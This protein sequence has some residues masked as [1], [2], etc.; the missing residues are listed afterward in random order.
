MSTEVV[1]FKNVSKSYGSTSVLIDVNLAIGGGDFLVTYGLPSSGKS[2]LLRLLVGLEKMDSG[3]IELRGR[4]VSGL[5]PKA[6]GLRYIPQD[7]A[8]FP[9]KTVFENIAYPLRLLREASAGIKPVV[10]RAAEMLSIGDLLDKLPTQ[11]SGG[12]KQRV[13]IAR[14]IVKETDVYILDDPLAGLDFKLR[15]KLIDDLKTLQEELGACFI[16]STSDPVEAMALATRLA[17]LHNG[18]VDETGDPEGLYVDPAM[19]STMEILGFPQTNFL[20]G[21]IIASADG[22]RCRTALFECA[23]IGLDGDAFTE[24]ES[25]VR[26]GFRPEAIRQAQADS[27]LTFDAVIDLR[28]DLGAEEIIYLQAG[29]HELKMVS[30]SPDSEDQRIEGETVVCIE[31]ESLLIF[32]EPTGRRIGTGRR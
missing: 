18:R 31:P 27:C 30:P 14:G 5:P 15:E 19:A 7:F 4:D 17:V 12:Q 23:A 8:L 20:S 24:A 13:A 3:S 9:H 1:E 26:V 6:R 22:P 28:E 16:Y 29:D 11:L 10:H 25:P 32:Q 21:E 2:V